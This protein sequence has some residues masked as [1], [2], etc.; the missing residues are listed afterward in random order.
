MINPDL[1][2][3]TR[4][5]LKSSQKFLVPKPSFLRSKRWQISHVKHMCRFRRDGQL[6]GEP[7][8]CRLDQSGR[9]IFQT[10]RQAFP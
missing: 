2:G 8:P 6:K 3:A 7:P 4:E 5:L 1:I 9:L 10:A